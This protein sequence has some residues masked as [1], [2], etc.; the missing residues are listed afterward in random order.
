[1]NALVS[2][3]DTLFFD[4]SSTSADEFQGPTNTLGEPT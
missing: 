1:M 2:I 3:S 4:V